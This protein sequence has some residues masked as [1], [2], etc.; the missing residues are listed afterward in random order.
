MHLQKSQVTSKIDAQVKVDP[1]DKAHHDTSDYKT[2]HPD[3]S[4]S[5][6]FAPNFIFNT[7]GWRERRDV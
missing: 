1:D 2:T 7:A 5:T 4:E 3:P 6:L